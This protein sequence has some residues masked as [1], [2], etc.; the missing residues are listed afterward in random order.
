MEHLTDLATNPTTWAALATLIVMEIVLGIDNLIFIS[1]LTNK[2]PEARRRMARRVGISLALVLRLALLGTVAIIVTLTAPVITVLG[3]GFSWRDL[4]LLAG[5]L[6]LVWKATKEISHT[7]NPNPDKKDDGVLTIGFTAAIVQIL[8]LDLVFSIDSII[9]AVGMTDNFAVMV[10]AVVVAVTVMM[11]AATPLADFIHANP[12]I[13]M[14]ALGFL[15]MIGM[16]LIA[17]AFGAHVPKGYMYAA[18]AFSALVEALNMMARRAR[19][20]RATRST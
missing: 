10:I 13:V 17:D 12:T 15:L 9:T 4:I 5:G 14:L 16:M 11:V 8:L 3:H 20:R 2:L 6:F 19:R 18:M 1:I 7:V